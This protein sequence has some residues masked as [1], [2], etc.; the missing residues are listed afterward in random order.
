MSFE[1]GYKA[2]NYISDLIDN[3]N[4]D[5]SIFIKALQIFNSY[6]MQSSWPHNYQAMNDALSLLMGSSH[7]MVLHFSRNFLH[8]KYRNKNIP[9]VREI[10]WPD[11]A[12]VRFI[13]ELE[14]YYNLVSQEVE[15]AALARIKPLKFAGLVRSQVPMSQT[16]MLKLIRMDG[17]TLEFEVDRHDVESSIRTLEI[18]IQDSCEINSEV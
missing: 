6:K 15:Q 2:I 4:K 7:E 17:E 3:Y 8:A 10:E 12:D 9:G 18:M 1:N 16:K 14:I 13:N 11:N 5:S